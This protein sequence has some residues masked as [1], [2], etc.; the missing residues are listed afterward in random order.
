MNFSDVHKWEIPDGFVTKVTDSN[1]NVIW[2]FVPYDPTW[3]LDSSVSFTSSSSTASFVVTDEDEVGYTFTNDDLLNVSETSTNNYQ[4][5]ITGTYYGRE[6]GSFP[7]SLISTDSSKTYKSATVSLPGSILWSSISDQTIPSNATSLTI[8]GWTNAS[9]LGIGISSSDNNFF[10]VSEHTPG[11]ISL[12]EDENG[13][14]TDNG[15]LFSSSMA[16][17]DTWIAGP[18]TTCTGDYDRY[19]FSITI[20]IYK[21]QTVNSKEHTIKIGESTNYQ[22]ITI[23]QEAPE[24]TWNLPTN[25]SVDWDGY[26][27]DFEDWIAVTASSNKNWKIIT[28]IGNL[29]G[30]PIGTTM[31]YDGSG[32]VSG[33]YMVGFNVNNSNSTLNGTIL[34]IDTDTNETILSC[35]VEQVAGYITWNLPS[36]YNI[37][38]SSTTLSCTI[39]GSSG[40]AWSISNSN[41]SMITLSRSSGTGS[42]SSTVTITKNSNTGSRA[43]SIL[44]VSA[45]GITVASCAITQSGSSS[46]SSVI[47]NYEARVGG[48]SDTNEM[49]TSTIKSVSYLQQ[50]ISMYSSLLDN[51]GAITNAAPTVTCDAD[52]VTVSVESG[53]ST[54]H[55]I[56]ILVDEYTGNIGR[57]ATITI[58]YNSN[59]TATITLIQDMLG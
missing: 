55:A 6:T 36:T 50:S 39:S 28:N 27:T 4:I 44:L 49:A 31:E 51:G 24:I 14:T 57:T 42:S 40:I 21:N 9:N 19:W 56:T 46:G 12:F 30:G 23:T 2:E 5:S 59:Y 13:P 32:T 58:A 7:I 41:T 25:I 16:G 33:E 38:S 34:L 10:W 8:T 52:W 29:D 26:Q 43:G 45:N 47:H 48:S 1:G 11:D 18:N 35:Y 15:N 22:E 53:R 37:N 20:P 17:G 54:Y 3:D